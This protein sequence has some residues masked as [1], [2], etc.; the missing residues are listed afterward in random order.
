MNSS[1]DPRGSSDLASG[2][3]I[4]SL[5]S[6]SVLM[7]LKVAVGFMT[8]SVAV[9]SDGIDSAQDMVA[10][11][12]A[13]A[14]VQYGRRP[15]D[16]AHPYGHGRA[17]TVAAMIQSLLIAGGGAYIV[18]RGVSRLLNPPDEIGTN[19][20][21]V[22]MA[23]S[24]AA[25]LVVVQYV[26]SV[27]RR[28]GSPAIASDARH[29]WTNVVQAVAVIFGL[30]L[31]AATGSVLFDPVVAIALA[32]YLFWTAGGILW[33]SL[34][35]ILDAS[36]TEE[37]VRYVE[38]AILAHRDEIAG[39]H[40]LRTRRSGQHRYI[41]F[42]L[43]QSPD[44]TVAEAQAICD[45]VKANILNRW[46][47]AVVTIQTEPADGRFLGPMQEAESRGREGEGPQAGERLTRR[48]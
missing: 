36:L 15:P 26:G 45:K 2:A 37:E 16:M 38:E 23:I 42:H 24:A 35:D 21:L 10:S 14:S 48:L 25:N 6:N 13:F 9:L 32:A 5:V 44:M 33:A 7:A 12:I 11:A 41:E 17:E 43:I 28:T 22:A 46:P 18:F 19:L 20:G 40:R 47:T 29:L 34:G 8:G 31:V 39:Y 4:L 3:A 27:A 30:G 1:P